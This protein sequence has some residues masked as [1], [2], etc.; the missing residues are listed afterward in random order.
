MLLLKNIKKSYTEGNTVNALNGVNIAFRQN[1][2]VA[3]LGPS[4]SGKTT[5]LNIVGGLDQY[6]DG[7]LVINGKSTKDFTDSDWDTYRNHSVGFVF[8]SYNLIPH[9]SVLSNV[10]LALTLTGVKRSERRERAR[11]ALEKVGLGDQ[12]SKKPNQMSGGQMQRVAIARALVNNP[13]ILLADEPTGALDSVTSLQIMELLKEVSRD[14]LVIMV[15]H[16]PDL[17]EQYANRII[18][19]KDGQVVDDTNPFSSE[20]EKPSGK[21]AKK[22][23]MSFLTALSLSLN[24]L[25]TKKARTFLTSFAGS[26]GIIGIALILALSSGVDAYINNVQEDTL[27]SYPVQI[28]AEQMDMS[29]LITGILN[30]KE[31]SEHERDAVYA[32]AVMY[33]LANSMNSANIVKNNLAGL[34]N[35][36]EENNKTVIKHARAIQYLYDVPLNIYSKDSDGKYQKADIMEILESMSEGSSMGGSFSSMGNMSQMFGGFSSFNTWGEMLSG[37]NGEAI[38]D[39]ILDQYELVAGSW[40]SDKTHITLVLDKNNEITDITLHALG[41]KSTDKIISDMLAA[42]KGDIVEQEVAKYSYEDI[43]SRTMKLISATDYYVDSDNNGIW[44]D[45]SKN[46]NSMDVI[47]SSGLELKV[48]GIIRPKDDANV[49]GNTTLYYTHDLTEYLI[50]R[51]N[52]SVI[53]KAQ[54]KEENKNLDIFTGLPFVLENQIE[55]TVEQAAKEMREHFKTLTPTEKADTYQKM[56]GFYKEEDLKKDVDALMANFPDRASLEEMIF[57]RYSS[58]TGVSKEDIEKFISEYSDEELNDL[59]RE[60][61]EKMLI[62]QRESKAKSEIAA[63]IAAPSESEL[64]SFKAQ[65]TSRLAD[66][67]TKIM[68]IVSEYTKTISLPAQTIMAHLMTLSDGEIDAIVDTLATKTATELYNQYASSANSD[69][70]KKLAD[71]FDKYVSALSD[72]NLAPMYDTC[73]PPK[74]SSSSLKDNLELLGVTDSQAPASIYIYTSTFAAKDSIKEMIEEYNL[75]ASEEDKI[76]YT[77]YVALIMSSVTTILDAITYVL[78]AFVSISL[79]VS[80]IMIGII[81][82]ISVLERTKEIGILRAMGASKKDVSRVF[83]A[84]T[85]IIGFV[86][87][88]IGVL[89]TVLICIPVNAIVR[90]VTDIPELT[91]YLPLEGALVLMAISVV[92]TVIAGLFPAR[93][94]AKKDPAV[95]LRSE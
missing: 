30:A 20:E 71:A 70:E 37:I 32:N 74:A 33:E 21:K 91:A 59:V 36:F 3:V 73:M 87:G 7:D 78:I 42:Q 14:R 95:A 12:I 16:N 92:L 9:Q 41:L 60:Q 53:V 69:S 64:N 68:Y 6:T 17:A 4:G 5:L 11:A 28:Q 8:Q 61:V 29:S 63:I 2:F 75:S 47:I 19:L 55:I 23:S 66:K 79:V 15:T 89:G 77:D 84:E 48:T 57:E 93:L 39:V 76:E 13:D 58:S 26:I 51:T 22:P 50:E 94:A 34:K 88:L 38:S 54:S 83:N 24:N 40:P 82:Y 86:A 81:T 85:L 44:E 80:S 72:E 52:S 27:T 18:K 65:I 56:L 1:E 35:Y 45:V 25:M 43:L 46:E 67:N 49:N 62:S 31:A 10:E 90:A